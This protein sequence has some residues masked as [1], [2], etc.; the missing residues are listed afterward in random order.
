MVAMG[1]LAV[2]DPVTLRSANGEIALQGDL[3]SF[4]GALYRIET[5]F[6]PMTLNAE[7][8]TCQGAA[9]PNPGDYAADLGFTA[10][11]EMTETL[12][13]LLFEEYAFQTG[14]F[15]LSEDRTAARTGWT[16]NIS[17][18]ARI[19]VA[20]IEGRAGGSAAG[21]A[22]LA[23]K[24]ADVILTTRGPDKSELAAAKRALGPTFSS[25][26]NSTI[27]ALDALVAVVSPDSPVRGISLTALKAVLNG[28]VTNWSA[29]GGPDARI[30]V[31]RPDPDSDVAAGFGARLLNGDWS[32]AAWAG[33]SLDRRGKRSRGPRS[34]RHRD[35]RFR[36]HPK[37][38]SSRD[39]GRMRHC[40]VAQP[41]CHYGG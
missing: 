13:P 5:R 41:I 39:P 28:Q 26:N 10:P 27:V 25:N 37:R 36:G 3:L 15:A 35:C 18:P 7:G 40:P 38:A 21:F 17:D 24:T 11:R 14:Q 22:A 6:G 16:Y 31:Y 20:R 9:C 23:G 33:V 30:V 19:P 12:L 34:V 4:D 32:G 1:S 8:I 29:L 2:A